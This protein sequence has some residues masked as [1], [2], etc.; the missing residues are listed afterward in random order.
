MVPGGLSVALCSTSITAPIP[1]IRSL[2][3]QKYAL[4]NYEIM[5][6]NASIIV[7]VYVRRDA[8]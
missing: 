6:R 3:V 2:K 4:C 7:F 8:N 5:L 1:E